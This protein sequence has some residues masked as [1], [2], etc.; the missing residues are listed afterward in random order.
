[1]AQDRQNGSSGRS[2]GGSPFWTAKEAAAYLKVSTDTIYRY[3][4]RKT[5]IGRH[6]QTH[7]TTNPPP[8]RRSG[9]NVLR[10]PIEEFKAWCHQY[11]SPK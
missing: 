10:F 3:C 4:K 2:A 5:D 8:F 7:L 11:D 6:P 1:M 9:R